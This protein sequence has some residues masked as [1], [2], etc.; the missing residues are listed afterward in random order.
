MEEKN[1]LPLG[2]MVHITEDP[3]KD[4][5]KVKDMGF[6]TC[7]IQN[8]SADYVA[9][10][11][12]EEL[13]RKLEEAIK[14]TGVKISS[15]FIMYEGHIWDL[16]DGPRTIGL[17]PENTRAQ[18]LEHACN[19]SDWAKK[20]GIDTVTSHIGFIPIEAEGL[21]YKGFIETMKEFTAH[22][23]KNNQI[24]AFET[25]QEPPHV[26]RRTIDDIGA[27]NIGVNLDPANLLLYG[28]GKPLEAVE[29]FGEFVV[30]TH[31]KDGK[32]PIGDGNLGQEMPLGQGDVNFPELITALYKKGF[33]GPLTIEREISGD[34]QTKDILAAKELLENIKQKILNI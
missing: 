27:D 19:I 26:L 17:V 25:G 9:G 24:F 32:W 14:K 3:E 5:Q 16:K 22:C 13:C 18:R 28:M 1:S 21:L 6:P 15:V 31:C 2:V 29:A 11:K 34:Q 33:R 23:A 4:L 12:S 8:P 7:Q 10:P 20:I 30:N